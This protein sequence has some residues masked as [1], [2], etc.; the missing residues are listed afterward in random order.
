MFHRWPGKKNMKYIHMYVYSF[1]FFY[2]LPYDMQIKYF[3]NLIEDIE[4][5][6]EELTAEATSSC[7]NDAGDGNASDIETEECP[8]EMGHGGDSDIEDEIEEEADIPENQDQ[9][10]FLAKDGTKWSKTPP[11]LQRMRQENIFREI[12][13]IGPNPNTKHLNIIDTFLN[14]MHPTIQSIIC[15]NTNRKGK[16]E[17]QK[18]ESGRI[19]EK[20]TK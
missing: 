20:N 14:I 12:R 19:V 9:D 5:D 4:S 17:Y 2:R 1:M 13:F 8:V 15:R 7:V 11:G 3:E 6:D 10:F 16:A 18:L